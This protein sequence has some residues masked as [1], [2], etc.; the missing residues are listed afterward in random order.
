[1]LVDDAFVRDCYQH[2]VHS[3]EP[4]ALDMD[5][6]RSLR[7]S[8]PAVTVTVANRG[9]P[10]RRRIYPIHGGR[11]AGRALPVLGAGGCGPVVFHF[12]LRTGHFI[13]PMTE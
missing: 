9:T 1:M 6:A 10:P 7:E 12:A 4:Y 11:A 13:F 2:D 3:P 8:P 5:D